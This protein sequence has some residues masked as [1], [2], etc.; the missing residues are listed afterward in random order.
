MSP[1]QARGE[2]H[3]AD[4]RADVYSLGVMLYQVLTGELPFRGTS[5]M[6]LHQVLNDD[7]RPPRRLNDRIPRDLETICLKAMAK[8]PARRY[9]SAAEMADDLRRFLGGEPIHARPSTALERGARWVKRKPAAATL[10]G[11][12]L[13]L[14]V[15]IVLAAGSV[16]H[17]LQLRQALTEVESQREEAQQQ[18]QLAEVNAAEVRKQR[19]LTVGS[20]QKRLQ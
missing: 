7:P 12:G 11:V 14:P 20:F 15:G 16:F 17:N 2:G 10:L 8:E 6:L 19:E 13:L 9:P 4:G 18:R 3:T 5:R 1:E